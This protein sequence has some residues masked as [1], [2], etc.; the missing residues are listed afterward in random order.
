MSI[1]TWPKFTGL[2]FRGGRNNIGLGFRVGQKIIG[3]GFRVEVLGFQYAR[4]EQNG[5]TDL[6]ETAPG[7]YGQGPM[8]LPSGS[9]ARNLV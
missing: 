5:A 3:L 2:G 9:L 1:T 8:F 7:A 6:P 4:N